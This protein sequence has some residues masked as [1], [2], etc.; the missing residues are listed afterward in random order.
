MTKYG[1]FFEDFF[2][3][4]LVG[5]QRNGTVFGGEHGVRRMLFSKMKEIT[6][7]LYT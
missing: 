4:S 5:E 3:F 1:Q 6:A 2:S 7:C